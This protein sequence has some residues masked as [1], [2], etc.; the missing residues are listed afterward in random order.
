M[1]SSYVVDVPALNVVGSPAPPVRVMAY[2]V[3]PTLSV[4]P[5][6]LRCTVLSTFWLATRLLGA[7]GAVLSAGVNV[8]VLDGDERLVAASAATTL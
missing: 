6:Q 7:V 8:A 3:T 1:V 5:V 2:S 4:D